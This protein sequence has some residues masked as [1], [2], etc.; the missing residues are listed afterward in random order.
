MFPQTVK[1]KLCPSAQAEAVRMERS[2]TGRTRCP[3]GLEA[4]GGAVKV[5]CGLLGG[6]V[7]EYH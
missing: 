6:G 4:A 7:A 1:V 5:G 2:R 3:M